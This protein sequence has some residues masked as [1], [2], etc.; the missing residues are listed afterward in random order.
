MT[1]KLYIRKDYKEKNDILGTIYNKPKQEYKEI[2]LRFR[3]TRKDKIIALSVYCMPRRY[4]RV[5]KVN[6]EDGYDIRFCMKD[7]LYYVESNLPNI[8]REVL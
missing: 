2:Y 3:A 4:D 6:L 5:F 8:L 7:I 1:F